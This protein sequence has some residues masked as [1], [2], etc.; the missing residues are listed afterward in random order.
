MLGK[1]FMTGVSKLK[2]YGYTYDILIFEKHL[3]N[4]LKFVE[5]LAANQSFVIDHI[6]KPLIKDQ[7]TEDWATNIKKVER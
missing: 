7:I 4:T 2:K 5:A 3:P 1:D 6:A